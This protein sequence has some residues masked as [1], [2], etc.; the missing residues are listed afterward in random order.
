MQAKPFSM[1]YTLFLMWA[2]ES[3]GEPVKAQMAG[4]HHQ[5]LIQFIRGG[6]LVCISNKFPND[7]DAAGSSLSSEDHLYTKLLIIQI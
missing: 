7:S 6:P 5:F 1:V 4:P 2:V 3:P